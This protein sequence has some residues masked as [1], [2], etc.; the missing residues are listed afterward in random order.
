MTINIT[1]H[2]G[3]YWEENF[4]LKKNCLIES[5]SRKNAIRLESIKYNKNDNSK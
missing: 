1:V 4:I 3:T 5:F 2:K